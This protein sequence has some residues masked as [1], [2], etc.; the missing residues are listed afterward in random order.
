MGCALVALVAPRGQLKQPQQLVRELSRCGALWGRP[1]VFLLL[2]SAPGGEWA[3]QGPWQ[4]DSAKQRWGR[5]GGPRPTFLANV[6]FLHP[7]AP[8]PGAFLTGLSE[9]CGRFP[10]WSLLQLL[11]EVR[12][13]GLEGSSWEGGCASHFPWLCCPVLSLLDQLACT[14]AH[15]CS[16]LRSDC[17]VRLGVPGGQSWE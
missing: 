6:L 13:P 1:K 9:L 4:R 11:T 3:G 7:A 8:E 14:S 2:S 12:G 5:A 15:P 17:P 16:H 10:H